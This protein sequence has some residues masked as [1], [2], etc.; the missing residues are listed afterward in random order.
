MAIYKAGDTVNT[1]YGAGVIVAYGGTFYSVRLWRVP[2]KS[3]GTAS[4]AR[5]GPSAVRT[6]KHSNTPS[7]LPC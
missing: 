3:V 1:S 4:L 7:F 5:L 6:N 2:G